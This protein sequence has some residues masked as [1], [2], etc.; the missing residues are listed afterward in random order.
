MSRLREYVDQSSELL[1]RC[2][3]NLPFAFLKDNGNFVAHTP[4][5]M[6]LQPLNDLP[7]PKKTSD[8]V[9]KKYVDDLIADNVGVG[10]MNGGVSP[11]FKKNGNYQATLAINMAFKKLLNL[12]T[13]SEPFEAATKD[14]VDK[15]VNDDGKYVDHKNA[16][17]KK[18]VDEL[19]KLLDNVSTVKACL[20]IHD[21]WLR[22]CYD[23]PRFVKSSC[24]VV[25]HSR[26]VVNLDES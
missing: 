16:N 22:C 24:T 12:S 21:F 20:H 5:S 11:F 7:E 1:G 23:S 25:I 10:N 17:I 26:T 9:T 8:A 2:F 4:I 6:A 18:E 19:I 3:H 13:T 14:Y 15:V